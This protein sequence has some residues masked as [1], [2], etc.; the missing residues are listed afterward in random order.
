MAQRETCSGCNK[1]FRNLRTHLAHHQ[2]CPA[3]L[4]YQAKAKEQQSAPKASA[5]GE[6]SQPTGITETEVKTL[7][8][9]AI[10]SAVAQVSE[11]FNT[12]LTEERQ[13]TQQQ[14]AGVGPAVLTYL[15][16]VAAKEQTEAQAQQ[17]ASPAVAQNPPA[18][19]GFGQL[20]NILQMFIKPSGGGIEQIAETLGSIGK[21]ADA[22]DSLRYRPWKDGVDF[23]TNNILQRVRMG[24]TTA[25]QAAE[26]LQGHSPNW[27]KPTAPP[28]GATP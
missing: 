24:G 7:L 3:A 19:D 28:S 17:A 1:S 13:A 10:S 23:A 15:R 21:L 8:T 6:T 18:G 22:L 12:R 16:E 4:E 27:A 5:G 9:E 26:D 20:A 25:E 2:E 14:L 11:A